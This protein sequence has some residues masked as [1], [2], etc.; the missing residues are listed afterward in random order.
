VDGGFGHIKKQFRRHD[1]DTLDQ[2]ATLV[3]NSAYSNK[4]VLFRRRDGG[5]EWEWL[6]WKTF[7]DARFKPLTA[8]Q[9]YQ[10]FRFSHAKPGYV[11]ARK[12][13]GG[14]EECKLLLKRGVQ[15]TNEERPQG[16]SPAGMSQARAQYLYTKVRP[17]VWPAFQDTTCPAPVEE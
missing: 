12:E 14:V 6:D 4:A 7:L 8:I 9:S 13:A 17:Y 15:I 2:L 5:Q 11:Y 10:H 3:D 1:C 16:I